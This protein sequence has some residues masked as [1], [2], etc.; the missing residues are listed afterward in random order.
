MHVVS[1]LIRKAP[2]IKSGCGQDGQ[3]T[4]YSVELSEMIKGWNGGETT[5]TNYKALMFA[6]TPNAIEFYNK[7]FSEGSF[8]VLSC[9]KLKIESRDHNGTTYITLL[10]DNAKLQGANYPEAAQ[11][12]G[13][14]NQGQQQKRP[15]AQQQQQSTPQYNEPTMD[16]DDDIPF[17]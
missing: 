12:W 5:Y 13:Q 14:P 15:P 7:A 17:N 4:M 16:F 11:G 10:M 1:G 9:E 3:S 8:V 2:F 6:K